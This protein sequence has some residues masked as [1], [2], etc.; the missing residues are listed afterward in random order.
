MRAF[1]PASR[2][3]A[4]AIAL[5]VVLLAGDAAAEKVRTTAATKVFKRTGE[6]SAIVTRVKA[7]TTLQVIATQGRWLKVRVNG[8]TGWV[9]RTSVVSMDAAVLPRNTRRRPFV[10]GRS[11][12]REDGGD[13]PGDR[14]GADTVDGDGDGREVVGGA[15]DDGD[16]DRKADRDDARKA[17][18]DEARR[19]PD[20]DV[21]KAD[22]D[23]RDVRDVREADRDVRDVRK[24]DRDEDDDVSIK[25]DDRDDRAARDRRKPDRDRKAD[26]DDDRRKPDRDDDRRKPDRDDD[27]KADRDDDVREPD[28]GDDD[29][30]APAP[31]L[32]VRIAR[33]ELYPRPS[34][35]A[36]AVLTLREGDRVVLL[37]EHRSG[38]WLRVEVADDD[39]V[40]GYIARD[41]VDQPGGAAAPAG[42]SITAS[43]RLGFASIGGTFHSDGAMLAAGPPP[44]YPFGSTAISLAIAGEATFPIKPR[45]LLGGSVRYLGCL[46][47]PGIAFSGESVGFTTHDVDLLAVGGYDLRD[48]RAMTVW[49]RAGFHFAR[50]SVDLAN[51]A[52]LPVETAFGPMVGAAV[53]LRRLTPKLGAEASIDLMP[54]ASRNQTKNQGDGQLAATRSLWVQLGGA[55]AWRRHWRLEAGY[56]LGYSS[57]RW[58][59]PSDRHMM[60]TGATRTDLAH[61][62][63]LGASRPF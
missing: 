17:D 52:K 1:V 46:G 62:L 55:Y 34:R 3:V 53:R 23:V 2:S 33:A 28:G 61:V 13:A 29:A 50:F 15:D 59:G 63:N 51:K 40:S 60:A 9:T 19:K 31:M 54:T 36:R 30:M 5:A 56:Q 38:A 35:N 4:R 41:A 27:R 26:R 11:M 8:R 39:A 48:A 37:E 43:A 21:R 14:V 57:S 32:T 45:I 49:A 25:V 7:G 22:R 10:D 58:A 18:R 47:S 6:Q 44:D 20:R 12:Q 42:R 24:A 16:D